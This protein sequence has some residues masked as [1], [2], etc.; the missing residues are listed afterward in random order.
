MIQKNAGVVLQQ[1]NRNTPNH[2]SLGRLYDRQLWQCYAHIIALRAGAGNFRNYTVTVSRRY[3][4]RTRVPAYVLDHAYSLTG[5]YL[6]YLIQKKQYWRRSE[7][8]SR[9]SIC[10]KTS[11]VRRLVLSV[12]LP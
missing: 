6:E 1:N 11:R 9:K 12:S 8:Y 7:F 3:A 10:I 5:T 4:T 2:Y